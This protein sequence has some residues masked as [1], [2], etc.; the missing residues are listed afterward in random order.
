MA[1]PTTTFLVTLPVT[2]RG[3]PGDDLINTL[4]GRSGDVADG[5]TGTDTCI[6]DAQ[7]IRISCP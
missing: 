7:D 6:T 4:N 3:G 1:S 2:L 5:G